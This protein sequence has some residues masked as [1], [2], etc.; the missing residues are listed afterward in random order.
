[1]NKKFL[2]FI[3]LVSITMKLNAQVKMYRDTSFQV[4]KNGNYL[5]N[6][7]AGGMN[8]PNMAS[9]DL[10]GDNKMDLIVFDWTYSKVFRITCYI[11]KSIGAGD[12]WTLAPEYSKLFP[13]NLEGWIRTY[14][15]D[16][17]GDMDLFTYSDGGYM[18]LYR[19]DYNFSIGLN[20]TLVTNQVRTFYGSFKSN[21]YVS[22]IDMPA[23]SDVD[24]DGDMDIVSFSLSGNFLEHN[25]NLSNENGFACGNIDYFYNLPN[26]WGY[27]Y[28]NSNYNSAVLSPSSLPACQ[29]TPANPF[30]TLNSSDEELRTRHSGSATLLL[31]LDGD[32]DKEALIGD[33]KSQ[34]LLYVKNCGNPDSAFVCLQDSAF[35]AYDTSA[36][37]FKQ[38]AAYYFDVDNDGNNDLIV[39]NFDREG[40]DLTNANFYRN[41]TNNTTNVFHFET[42]YW[43]GNTMIDV[44][45]SAHPVLYDING[46]GLKDLILGNDLYRVG[47]KGQLAYYKNIGTSS[48]AKFELV[49]A[50]LANMSTSGVIGLYPTFG[51]LDGDNDIDMLV[52]ESSGGIIQYQNVAGPGVNPIYVFVQV[53]YQS[54]GVGASAAPQLIDVDRDGKLDL[55]IGNRDGR[56][57]YFRNTSLTSTPIFTLTSSNFGNVNVMKTNATVGYSA[58]FLFDVNGNYELL[59][60]SEQGY[61]YHYTNIDGNLSGSFTLADSMYQ[62]IYEATR[63]VPAVAD[64]DGDAKYDLIVGNI[65]GGVALY[66]QNTILSLADADLDNGSYFTLY[67][68]PTDNIVNIQV[69]KITDRMVLEIFDVTGKIVFKEQVSFLTKQVDCTAFSKGLYIVKL[70]NAKQSFI[71]KLII[72]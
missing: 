38:A 33:I 35:P 18:A 68:N 49:T 27:F 5:R 64:L 30:R 6:P 7:W 47:S 61:L 51:D 19:N 25:K 57:Y 67:P 58:P 36:N 17:D 13:E 8:A 63:S 54:I 65:L 31:D 62:N 21:V 72:K 56:I 71:Q 14:D 42:N 55:I 43:L 40:E 60:G 70:S 11:N 9:I 44:G 37:I 10:N 41:T 22:R 32:G 15:Y 45:S 69:D 24:N 28:T 2:V 23:L 26:C 59:V 66:S 46:D 48:K 34:N 16:C 12:K 4:L 3:F 50:D 1:M 53:N 39:S 20:F 52:G 29:L